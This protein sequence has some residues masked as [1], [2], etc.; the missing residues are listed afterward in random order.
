[1]LDEREMLMMSYEDVRL[2]HL[3]CTG[4]IPV[5]SR[6]DGTHSQASV[7]VVA[8]RLVLLESPLQQLMLSQPVNATRLLEV[9][10]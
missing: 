10:C 2:L 8:S 6:T 3:R 9:T 5:I 7:A 4:Q 1:M